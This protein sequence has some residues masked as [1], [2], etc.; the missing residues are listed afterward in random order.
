MSF[1]YE[2]TSAGGRNGPEP[3]GESTDQAM[4][5]KAWAGSPAVPSPAGRGPAPRSVSR[6]VTGP[7][8]TLRPES[9]PE[10]NAVATRPTIPQPASPH[11]HPAPSCS[12]YT[13]T[14]LAERIDVPVQTLSSWLAHCT[15]H[16]PLA[17]EIPRCTS[18]REY[19]FRAA[20]VVWFET[21]ARLVR[22]GTPVARAATHLRAARIRADS[23]YPVPA[24]LPN[25]HS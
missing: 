10:P 22:S 8:A 14:E 7:R 2:R 13:V 24:D 25:L 3:A 19:L 23:P 9:A 21:L 1:T 17:P 15:S 6:T 20:D 18:T 11:A 5:R 12:G 4:Y 16:A